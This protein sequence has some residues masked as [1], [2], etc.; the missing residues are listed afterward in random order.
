[1]QHNIEQGS[2]AVAKTALLSP[3]SPL[4]STLDAA[5]MLASF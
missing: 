5:P 1:M 3:T 2:T 4:P